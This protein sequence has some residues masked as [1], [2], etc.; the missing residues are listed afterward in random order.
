[1]S[2]REL[3]PHV[4]GFIGRVVSSLARNL[5]HLKVNHVLFLAILVCGGA[6]FRLAYELR[7]DFNI[8]LSYQDQCWTLLP[9]VAIMKAAVFYLL[10]GLATNWRFV[11]LRDAFTIL[12]HSIIAAG[13]LLCLWLFSESLRVPRGVIIIDAFLGFVLTGGARLT[14]RFIR[15]QLIS[16]RRNGNGAKLRSCVIIGAGDAGEMVARE[17]RRNPAS[18]YS[19][20]AFFDD[21]RSKKGMLIHGIRV[22]GDVKHVKSYAQQFSVDTVII[23]IPSATRAQMTRINNELKGLRLSIKTLPPLLEIM[24]KSPALQQLR[25]IDIT[26]LLGRGEVQIDTRQVH[27]LI[28]GKTVLITGAGGSIG[29]ELCRQVMRQGPKRLILVDHSENNL[30]HVHRDLSKRTFN[31]G[32]TDLVP[33]LCDVA[34]RVRMPYQVSKYKPQLVLHAAAHKHVGMQE[35]NP[36]QCF[37]NNVGGLQNLAKACHAAGVERFLL[38]STDKAVNPRSVMGASKR[39]CEIYCQALSHASPTK[40]MSVRFG[41]VLASEGSVVPIFMEQISAGGPITV[42]HPQVRRYFMTIPEAV[43]LILQ[44]T[45]IGESGQIMILNMGEPIKIVDLAKQLVEITG[46]DPDSIEIEFTGL[47]EGEKLTEELFCKGEVCARTAH[48]KIHIFDKQISNPSR[49]LGMIDRAVETVEKTPNSI[50]IRRLLKEIVP[51]YSPNE[52]AAVQVSNPGP[53]ERE[54]RLDATDS[55][56][57][58]LKTT[59]VL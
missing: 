54:E 8:P 35:M 13:V 49:V 59:S 20:Q 15:E 25:D 47:K 1:M 9:Y 57:L 32:A 40:F 17:I 41:N 6:S 10:G 55:A 53:P 12:V 29:S 5:P 52:N 16:A 43:T 18:G 4:D 27:E 3:M 38:V 39:V 11:G 58:D 48:E 26:D 31:G 28:N 37:K 46:A 51:E 33:L 19:L 44:A 36:L 14:P 7:F 24:D 56:E 2:I 42:T 23:A 22:A 50:D 30:F 34:D 45:A 21:D